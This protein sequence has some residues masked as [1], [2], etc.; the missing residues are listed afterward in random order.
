M[1]TPQSYSIHRLSSLTSARLQ[2]EGIPGRQT[3]LIFSPETSDQANASHE[4][5]HAWT[6]G[7]EN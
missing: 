1:L 5:Q 7:K 6:G 4:I 2:G 3:D